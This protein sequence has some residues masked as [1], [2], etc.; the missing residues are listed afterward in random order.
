MNGWLANFVVSYFSN[1]ASANWRLAQLETSS[2]L[3]FPSDGDVMHE[4]RPNRPLILLK[5]FARRSQQQWA[6]GL[7]GVP[8]GWFWRARFL[9]A[10]VCLFTGG[11]TLTM[12]NDRLCVSWIVRPRDWIVTIFNSATASPTVDTTTSRHI[13]RLAQSNLFT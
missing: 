4:G 3:A 13:C 12:M 2:P 9:C 11:G 10:C 1:F 5:Q 6:L 8:V 7:A